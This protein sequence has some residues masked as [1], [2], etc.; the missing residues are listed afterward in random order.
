MAVDLDKLEAVAKAATPGPWRVDPNQHGI[1]RFNDDVTTGFMIGRAQNATYVALA[2]PAAILELVE[3]VRK[4]E[5]EAARALAA[6]EPT[7]P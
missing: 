4:A 1:V 5:V 3:R 7:K 2:N 6:L